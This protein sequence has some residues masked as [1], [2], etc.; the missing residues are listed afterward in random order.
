MFAQAQNVHKTITHVQTPITPN[1][2]VSHTVLVRRNTKIDSLPN[3]LIDFSNHLNT[4]LFAEDVDWDTT[5]PLQGTSYNSIL[6]S[7]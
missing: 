7:Q 6:V 1:K 2:E 4:E 3:N 5:S